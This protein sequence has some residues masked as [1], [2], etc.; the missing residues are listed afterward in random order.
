MDFKHRIITFL[1]GILPK[2]KNKVVFYGRSKFE[3]NQH[4]MVQYM[5]REHYNDKYKIFLVV[6]DEN[7]LKNYYGTKNVFPVKSLAGGI[8]HTLTARYVFHCW[9]WGKMMNFPPKRQIVF[10][11]WHGTALKSLGS[12]SEDY[13]KNSDYILATSS[14]AKDYFKKCFGYKEEQFFI[15]G[16]PRCDML[17][18]NEDVLKNFGIIKSDYKKIILYMPTFRKASLWGVEDS[19]EIFP[20]FNEKNIASF[21]A[22]LCAENVLMII[23]PHPAQ[24]EIQFLNDAKLS[25]IIVLK[26]RNLLEKKTQV[27][28]LAAQADVLLTDYSSIYFDFLLTQRPIGFVIDD[29]SEYGENRGFVVDNP[30]D[31]MPGEKI[32]NVD[33][34]KTFIDNI[35]DGK[36]DWKEERKRINDLVNV[37]QQGNY[38]KKILDFVGIKLK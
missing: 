28:E 3:S 25:N 7:E 26:N 11:I 27:Y 9:G 12:R 21:N 22:F 15:C 24:D 8:W 10:D 6:S 17:F 5:I 29:I 33:E 13:Y 31:Y 1:N 14:F 18:E 23:K 19:H 35:L 34:L 37:D 38:S 16:Y 20:L 30:L 4:A 32:Q 36:D 2:G